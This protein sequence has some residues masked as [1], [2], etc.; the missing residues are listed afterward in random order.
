MLKLLSWL[1]KVVPSIYYIVE[2]NIFLYKWFMGIQWVWLK[3]ALIVSVPSLTLLG[4]IL[5]F[6]TFKDI[7]ERQLGK[8]TDENESR[9]F[10]VEIQTKRMIRKYTTAVVGGITGAILYLYYKANIFA[11]VFSIAIIFSLFLLG[12]ILRIVDIGKKENKKIV[13]KLK[14]KEKPSV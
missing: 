12:E 9:N 10:T 3:I 5:W 8:E 2:L 4:V 6:T 1:L 11:L 14:Q 7:L 13:E